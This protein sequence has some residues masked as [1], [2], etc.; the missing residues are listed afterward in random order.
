MY[1][2]LPNCDIWRFLCQSDA[3]STSTSNSCPINK[4]PWF[5]ANPPTLTQ[6]AE[7]AERQTRLI[8][9]VGKAMINHNNNNNNNN[10]NENNVFIYSLTYS[11]YIY[12]M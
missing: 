7:N 9:N 3:T 6:L 2:I 5:S 8:Q 1:R 11:M 4:G 10:D 12:I